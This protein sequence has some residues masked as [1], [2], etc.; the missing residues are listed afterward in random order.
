MIS[1]EPMNQR[2]KARECIKAISRIEGI[3]RYIAGNGLQ[4]DETIFESIDILMKYFDEL[5]VE[6][7]R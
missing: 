4:K 1:K 6:L 2:E 3:N 5:L 7:D